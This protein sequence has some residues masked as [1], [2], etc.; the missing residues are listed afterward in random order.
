MRIATVGFTFI[1]VGVSIFAFT[2]VRLNSGAALDPQ[3]KIP[4]AV[5]AEIDAPGRYYVWDNHRTMFDGERIQYA[6]GWPDDVKIAVRDANGTDLEFVHDASQNWSIGN[7]AKTSVGYIDVP[8][9]TTIRI[10][11]DGAGRDRIVTVANRTIKQELWARLS[12][13][14]IGLIVGAVGVPIFLLGLLLRRRSSTVAR[15]SATVNHG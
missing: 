3:T 13:L 7:N 11:I 15:D 10:D 9:A 12:G 6:S 4:G 8:T 1:I 5:S 2:L 14:G